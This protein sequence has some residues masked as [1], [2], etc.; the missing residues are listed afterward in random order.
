M[1]KIILL[2]I[3]FISAC[4]LRAQDTI[5]PY[6]PDYPFFKDSA[7]RIVDTP[8]WDMW[9]YNPCELRAIE[10]KNVH[11]VVTGLALPYHFG[12]KRL[13][14]NNMP[15]PGSSD[16]IALQGV[17]IQIIG[18]DY[19]NPIIHYTNPVVWNYNET[20]HVR[21]YDC[22]LAFQSSIECGEMDTVL[23]AYSLYFDE[24][25]TVTGDVFLGYRVIF[26][27]NADGFIHR[28]DSGLPF[29]TSDSV[30]EKCD[31]L[32]PYPIFL[33]YHYPFYSGDP[34][35][36]CDPDGIPYLFSI[37]YEISLSLPYRT[38]C[39]I[40]SMPDTDSFVCPEV[41]GFGFAGM[42]AGS[43]T[44]AW[45]T[46]AEH[47]LY[48]LAYGPYDAP[49]DSLQ[50]RE[51]DN[52]F[53]EL[54]DPSLSR[55]IYYQA[56]LRAKCHH[57]CPVHDTVMWTAW[58]EPVYFYTGDQMPDTTHHHGEP[59][60]IAEV[61]GQVHF[62]LAPNPAHGNV[63]LTLENVPVAG[64]VLTIHDGAGREVLR[65]VLHERVTGIETEGMAGG[66]YTVTVSN[67]QGVATRRLSVE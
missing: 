2:F 15:E 32:Y 4:A 3:L 5:Y 38:I 23:E 53:L 11:A 1:K 30:E 45:D 27:H 18:N 10:H 43:P 35:N 54:S 14:W 41:E 57:A 37:L 34:L 60:G 17:L 21:P 65:R 47:G 56:R 62:A 52:Y 61:R 12:T 36:R 39:P 26:D 63:T 19:N 9:D 46:A 6:S 33:I 67:P 40:V 55:D 24:P 44:F 51:T 42:M 25:I 8:L 22:Y 20:P 64:T 49:L 29:P 16:T 66:V 7:Y 31:S 58:T 50:V 28:D 48:Q 59:E 13:M